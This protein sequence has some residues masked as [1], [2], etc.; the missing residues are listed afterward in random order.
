M[1]KIIIV[2]PFYKNKLNYLEKIS[3]HQMLKILKKYPKCFLIPNNQ[4]MAGVEKDETCEMLNCPIE[5][6]SDVVSYS[7]LLLSADFYRLFLDYEYLLIYQ[8]DAFVFS[9]KL[10]FFCREKIDYI[11]APWFRTSTMYKYSRSYIGNGGLSLRHIEH[12][13]KLLEK[14][15]KIIEEKFYPMLKLF[16][17]DVVISYLGKKETEY[18]LATIEMAKKFSL[19]CNFQNTY[20][21][22]DDV[23][24]FGCHHWWN[25]DFDVWRKHIIGQGYFLKRKY[26]YAKSGQSKKIR[27]RDVTCYLIERIIRNGDRKRVDSI[28]SEIFSKDKNVIIWG[29]GE[30]G[31]RCVSTMNRLKVSFDFV[32]DS[33]AGKGDYIYGIKVLKPQKKLIKKGEIIVASTKYY[34]EICRCL[35]AWGLV[36]NIDFFHYEKIE[37][38]IVTR[39]YKEIWNTISNR[40]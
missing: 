24:P 34:E 4:D 25:C 28:L 26:S 16:G 6:F 36:E 10:E 30:V 2:V 22:L 23:L 33:N 19:E 8:F 20:S 40:L 5:W 3:L 39:Y 35:K 15:K 21:K 12:T 1:Y 32:I 38:C 18:K 11:G 17:E 29:M 9:D 31:K 7:K 37:I 14:N 13:I 27:I